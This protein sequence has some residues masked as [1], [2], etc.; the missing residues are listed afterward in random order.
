MRCSDA[1]K[2][3]KEPSKT[4]WKRELNSWSDGAEI[5]TG[6]NTLWQAE[7]SSGLCSNTA[8]QRD[9]PRLPAARGFAACVLPCF[10]KIT[11]QMCCSR[12][13]IYYWSQCELSLSEALARRNNGHRNGADLQVCG[14]PLVTG[15]I[16]QVREHHPSQ[17]GHE[18]QTR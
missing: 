7:P 4:E 5:L 11:K 2:K 15:T 17:T 3:T 9:N 1:V 12:L 16:V 18:L 10:C 8:P 14:C 13:V 6:I